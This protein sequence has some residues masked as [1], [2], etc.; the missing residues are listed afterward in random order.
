MRRGVSVILT[1]AL[2]AALLPGSVLAQGNVEN[3]KALFTKHCASCHG[4][5]GKGDAPAAAA[6]NPKPKDLTNK[7]YMAGLK[8]EYIF[9][10]VKKGGAAV[11]KSPLIPPF[12]AQMK[13]QDIRDVI[14]FLRSLAK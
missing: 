8:D 9:D 10:L 4:A 5:G 13:D 12:G 3:G 11:G 14:A 2:L 7:A 1:V 6:L